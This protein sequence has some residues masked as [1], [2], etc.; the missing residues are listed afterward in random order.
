MILASGG[1][2][3]NTKM[4]QKYNTYWTAI[5]DDVKTTNSPAMT[6][7]GIRLGTSVGAALVGMGF[8]QM[9]PVSDPETGELFSGLQVPPA[10]FVMVNQQGKRFVNEYG[11]RDELT[12]AAIDNGSLFYLIADDE[13]KKTAYNTTQAKI[14]QQVANGTLFRADT[15]TD[16]AHQIGMD[17]AAP[18]QDDCGL[19]SLR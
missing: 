6:G 10:N 8:S 7:D 11:S 5:D 4:L 9:M 16:L 19:Q 3:A 15:L 18:D 14:D 2:A 12:Q 17:P 13:I 1:F